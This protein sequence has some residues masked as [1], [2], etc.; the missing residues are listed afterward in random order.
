MPRNALSSTIRPLPLWKDCYF[1][2]VTVRGPFVPVVLMLYPNPRG[3]LCVNV[4]HIGRQGGR[5]L[6]E[7]GSSSAR[8]KSTGP[9]NPLYPEESMIFRRCSENHPLNTLSQVSNVEALKLEALKL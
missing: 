9:S 1:I 6:I 8:E 3:T 7:A 2:V 5:T 4:S